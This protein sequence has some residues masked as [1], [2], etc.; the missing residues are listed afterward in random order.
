MSGNDF[1]VWVE[2]K[3]SRDSNFTVYSAR[4]AI[5]ETGA[6]T[7]HESGSLRTE[8]REEAFVNSCTTKFVSHNDGPIVGLSEHTHRMGSEITLS[9]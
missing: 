2:S 1:L 6:K 5:K 9:V 7:D 4:V 3:F 8:V